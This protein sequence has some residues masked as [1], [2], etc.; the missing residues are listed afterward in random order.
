MPSLPKKVT[1]AHNRR[2]SNEMVVTVIK[3][4]VLEW[5]RYIHGLVRNDKVIKH[6]RVRI[7]FVLD[8]YPFS[9]HTSGEL[10]PGPRDTWN[11]PQKHAST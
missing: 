9:I 3:C 11:E 8:P 5:N 6:F 1:R 4:L 7:V 2:I 10:T